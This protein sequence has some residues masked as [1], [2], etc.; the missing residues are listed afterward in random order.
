MKIFYLST[1]IILVYTLILANSI[2]VLFQHETNAGFEWRSFGDP[3]IQPK[4]EGSILNDKPNGSGKL[5]YSNGNKF[6]GYWKNGE[7]SGEGTFSWSDGRK[8]SGFFKNGEP[9]GKG[10]YTSSD[11][12]K[13]TGMWKDTKQKSSWYQKIESSGEYEDKKYGILSYR[14][15][16]ARW[17][18][19]DY[20]DEKKDGKY[21]GGIKNMKPNGFGTFTYGAGKWKGDQ[22]EGMW[23]D[24]KFNGKGTLT[25]SNGEKFIGEWKNNSLWNIS[26]QS[27]FG[28]ILK[29]YE[30]GLEISFKKKILITKKNIS[31]KKKEQ[32]I[33]YT[34]TPRS[35]WDDRVREW[36][37]NGND[38]SHGKYEGEILNGLPNGKGIYS[39]FDINKYIGEFKNGMFHGQGTFFSSP[40]KIKIVGE[41]KKDKEWNTIRTNKDG[42][43]IGKYV[44]GKLRK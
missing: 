35:K 16:N 38:K 17:G 34:N 2:G 20:G 31:L 43:I 21:I 33:L 9:N 27:K 25:R 7:P 26:K 40:S 3:K 44:N 4:F 13:K 23:K 32:G 19:F 36:T 11:G 37:S 18:W 30:N 5:T 29:K 1:T 12:T 24:G 41:Y 39:W 15:E 28:E 14:K 6:E 10:T 8:Y 42:E 22:Y